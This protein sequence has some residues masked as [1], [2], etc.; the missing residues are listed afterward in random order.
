MILNLRDKDHS[1]K[2]KFLKILFL[3]KPSLQNAWKSLSR[4]EWFPLYMIYNLSRAI[5]IQFGILNTPKFTLSLLDP[6]SIF[7]NQKNNISWK[8]HW[9]STFTKSH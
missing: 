2:S 4:L 7:M 5:F 6:S 9:I 3:D 1:L 8:A